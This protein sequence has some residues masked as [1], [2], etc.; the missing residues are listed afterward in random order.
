VWI[1]S[2]D[3]CLKDALEA[4]KI[5]GKKAKEA[6]DLYEGTV[7]EFVRKGM[8]DV[9][10]R[11]AA[12]K[13]VTEHIEWVK[14]EQKRRT[15][16]QIQK[17][18]EM[19]RNLEDY[20][21]KH[22]LK[23]VGDAGEAFFE[24]NGLAPY[25]NYTARFERRRGQ[26]HAKIDNILDKF[27]P[28]VAGIVRPK[29]GLGNI[30]RELF[31]HDTGDVS[32]REL[33]K[34]WA[35][36]A[37][38]ARK[39]FVRA[40][41]SMAKRENWRLPQ[42]QDAAIVRKM[43]KDQW[44]R[45]HLD[46]LDWNEM[47]NPKTGKRVPVEDR[48]E[49]LGYVYDTIASKGWAHVKAGTAFRKSIGNKLD[50]H[51]FLQYK[52]PDAWLQMHEK[53]GD[54]SVFDAMI[55]YVDSMSRDI[56]LMETF[57][58]NPY[59]AVEAMKA[60]IKNMAGQDPNLVEPIERRLNRIDD[61]YAIVTRSNSASENSGMVGAFAAI[62]NILVSAYLGSASLL[63]M[64]T[65][66]FTKG[67]TKAFNKTPGAF[68][69]KQYLKLMNPASSADRQFAIR[70]G[71]IAENA[72]SQ[73]FAQ[74]RFIGDVMGPRMTRRISDSV[75]RLSLLSPH[76]QAARWAF[77]MEMMG[78]FSDYASKG[79]DELP[80]KE[81]FGRHGITAADWDLFRAT[82]AMDHKGSKF[83]RPDDVLNRTDL[84]EDQ[85]IELADKFMDM[86]LAEREYAVPT[87]S[88]RGRTALTGATRPDTLRGQLLRSFALFKNFPVTILMLH[89]RR[90]LQQSTTKGKAA[91]LAAFG[92]GMTL[93]GGLALQARE[94][95]KG[96][97]PM[98]MTSGAFWGKAALAGGGLGI[99]GDFLF[100]GLNRFGGGPTETAAGPVVDFIGDTVDLTI[101]NVVE[102]MNGKDT[103]LP[104][105]LV[106]YFRRHTPGQ[107]IWYARAV[108]QRLVWDQLQK[109]ADPKAY[110]KFQRQVNRLRRE[111][112]Q[113]YWWRPGAT[114]PSRAPDLSK[115]G[116]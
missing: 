53:Y 3:K 54:G 45:D 9:E 73:A 87:A 116:G 56:A 101:G 13:Q 105:E 95:S 25:S 4:K 65:D 83:L 84:A 26:L 48:E 99:W 31:G 111:T 46:W 67:F 37:E 57:G 64:S 35:D 80:F 70:S 85:K 17:Q 44:M 7:E 112:G 103:H 113:S 59:S 21:A 23:N 72:T 20:V 58:P 18:A 89:G 66:N 33:A 42:H 19:S 8:S 115:A 96:R 79:F 114:E 14:A 32:A 30:V 69:L 82:E 52:D 68:S 12:A 36:A 94:I 88:L 6:I 5:T 107:N 43:G 110:Q 55:G 102:F 100:S 34:A 109:E 86:I 28:K 106:Q 76:T 27:Q 97:D 92:V 49:V 98:D 50:Q 61:F 108:L 60:K 38:L 91:Y 1:V 63:A 11:T 71:L 104:S 74:A 90:G 40:G 2:F 22:G 75:L 15:F 29:A 41:G 78:A 39:M 47:R 62:N 93:T 81:M 10:A 77:G 51:R 16:K 24:W